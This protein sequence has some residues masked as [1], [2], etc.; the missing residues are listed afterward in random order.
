MDLIIR[1]ARR[2]DHDGTWDIGIDNGQIA[3]IAPKLAAAATQEIDAAGRL[4]APSYVNGHVHLDKCN[5]GDVMRPNETNS[6]Q[7][8]LGLPGNISAPIR[9]RMSSSARAG[10]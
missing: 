7:E 1:N 5:L 9:S 3:E 6:F 8:C 4:A 2:L 10:R